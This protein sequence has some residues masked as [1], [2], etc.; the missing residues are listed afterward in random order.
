MNTTLEYLNLFHPCN[1]VLVV[2]SG[3]GSWVDLIASWDAED[4]ILVE[5]DEKLI[6]RMKKFHTLPREWKVVN[7]LVYKDHTQCEY[8][9]TSNA[10]ASCLEHPD[11]L[12]AIWPNLS[13]NSVE[14]R[15]S[16]SIPTL[17]EE[18]DAQNINWLIIDCTPAL[19]LLQE[20][21]STVVQC[22]VVVARVLKEEKS[23]LDA[24]MQEQGLHSATYFEENNP[25]VVM[26]VYVKEWHTQ[27]SH[28]QTQSEETRKELEQLDKTLTE[29]TKQL[30]ERQQQASELQKKIND[31]E[32]ANE[33]YKQRQTMLE[34]ELKKA[35]MQIEI[36]KDLLMSG[37]K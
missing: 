14:V 7:A 4:V 8:Y 23:V 35:E 9:H 36:I 17:L 37:N 15:E 18:V 22:D 13:I 21:V 3:G 31:T 34:D 29:K 16:V 10:A 27:L 6:E 26:V 1:G 12:S 11:T 32:A 20:G 28:L 30:T 2:G 25:Q 24:W 19:K 5:A 33:N